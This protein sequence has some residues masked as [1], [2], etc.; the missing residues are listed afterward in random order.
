MKMPI[1][2]P[3]QTGASHILVALQRANA[4]IDRL[5]AENAEAMI[6]RALDRLEAEIERTRRR[7]RER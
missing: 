5:Q 7:S 3:A 2:Q 1:R 4:E 6:D